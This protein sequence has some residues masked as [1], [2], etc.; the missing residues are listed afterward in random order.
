L[1]SRLCI[2]VVFV[3]LR[4]LGLNL[5]L[6]G[7]FINKLRRKLRMKNEGSVRE[8]IFQ[9]SMSNKEGAGGSKIRGWIDALHWVLE[10]KEE[11]KE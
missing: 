3:I 2:V 4:C 5:N 7:R 11:E 9:L 10:S 1:V 8:K 6:S